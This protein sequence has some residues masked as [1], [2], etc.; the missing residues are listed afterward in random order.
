VQ[1]AARIAT[2]KAGE[3]KANHDAAALEAAK[4]ASAAQA[5]AST[6][7]A[8]Q[9]ALKTIAAAQPK[10]D[11]LPTVAG[12]DIAALARVLGDSDEA[13]ALFCRN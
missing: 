5:A 13:K 8:A 7:K 12:A 6:A 9:N 3:A 1:E 10:S 11:G 2:D 4:A